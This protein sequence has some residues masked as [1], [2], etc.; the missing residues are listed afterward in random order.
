MQEQIFRRLINSSDLEIGGDMRADS[1]GHCAKFGT[2][3]F[4][5][6]QAKEVIH[7]ELLQVNHIT[8]F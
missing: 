8:T 5:N 2:Y 4:M 3:V 7:I 1:P 6:L